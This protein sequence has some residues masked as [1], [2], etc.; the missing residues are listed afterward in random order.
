MD[1]SKKLIGL[2]FHSDDL[3]ELQMVRDC[4]F[5]A[6]R[7]M[8]PFPWGDKLYG[9]LTERYRSSKDLIRLAKSYG[10]SIMVNTPG[11]GAYFFNKDTQTT[12]WHDEF[13]DFAGI[14]G[15][16]EFY[17]NVRKT[18]AWIAEDLAEY[19][20]PLWC[21]MNEIDIETFHG[22]YSLEIAA[23]TAFQSA[24]GVV[25]ADPKAICGINLSRY[26]EDAIATAD[27]AYRSGHSFGYIGDDQYFGSWQG[28]DVEMWNTVIEKLHER[29]KLPVVANEWGY[30]S[31][32]VVVPKPESED[33][34]PPG[35]NSVCH[36]FG[37]HH[38]VEGGHTPEV[39]AAYL[40]RGFEIFAQSPHVIASFLFCW[41][42]AKYCY[43]CGRELCPSECFWGI[44][45]QDCKPK[46]AY[47]AVKEA[48]KEFYAG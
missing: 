31:G 46:P 42:D 39:Q 18:C 47:Y 37:W 38:E 6:L 32:G 8:V 14:K 20:G 29:Y 24:A 43:H 48:I 13:P 10:F 41:K 9:T 30:S 27:M 35:L 44:V 12:L 7:L 15:T 5:N 4:G 22:D 26:Y 25:S 36:V 11:L 3:N 21:H 34:I 33:D 19:A 28:H 45:D 40:R 16:P 23:E 1:K 2:C 17:E